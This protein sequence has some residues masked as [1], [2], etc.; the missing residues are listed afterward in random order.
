MN[1]SPPDLPSSDTRPGD[2]TL[3]L[4]I[5]AVEDYA[6]FMLDPTGHVASWNAGAQQIKGYAPDDIIGRHFSVFYTPDDLAARK[7]QDELDRAARDGRVE[8]EGWRVRKDGSRFW[9]NVVI[10][11]VRDAQGTLVGFAKV[12]RDLTERLRVAELERSRALAARAHIAR[13][14]EQRRMARELHDDLGQQLVALKMDVGVLHKDLMAADTNPRAMLRTE[15]VLSMIDTIIGSV[16]RIASDLRPPLLDD[17]GLAA[18]I[19]WLANDFEQRHAITVT[20]RVNLGAIEMNGP[21][22]SSLFRI[23]QEALNNVVRHAGATRVTVDLDTGDRALALRIAD[24][25]V[26]AQLGA[27]RDPASFG[28]L[29][30]GER[31][32]LLG[33]AIAFDSTPGHGFRISISVPIDAVAARD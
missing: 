1:A 16:R 17:L 27:E 29:G 31:V 10:T 30:M 12:T 4:F 9:A 32:H 20:A 15:R 21:A 7:P 3:A 11:A 19:E 13:E 33:G 28:L 5:Q 2:R 23:V 24:N 22:A 6:I 25:G 18:A 14:D 26:G 8:D